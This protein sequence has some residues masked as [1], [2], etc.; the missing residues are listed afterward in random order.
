MPHRM[1][2]A[3]TF[4]AL[5]SVL[6]IASTTAAAT[7]QPRRTFTATLSGGGV[8]GTAVVTL[9]PNS[10]GTVTVQ[11]SGLTPNKVYA[12]QIYKGTCAKP[13]TLTKL[14]GL[15]TDSK[16]HGARTISLKPASGAPIWSV[17][18]TGTVAFRISAGKYVKCAVLKYPVATRVEISKYGIDLPIVYE[19]PGKYPYCNVAMYV[20]ELSQPTEAGPTMI[21]AHARVGMFLPL[22]TASKSNNG[23][24]MLGML[25][26]VWTS[27]SRL[28]V[29]KVTRVLRNVYGLPFG[30]DYTSERLWLQTSE[31]PHGTRHKLFV[32]ATRISTAPATWTDAHPKPKIV[33]CHP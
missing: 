31:G 25:V 16:G 10:A 27:D 32:Q 5:L 26:K 29:Y 7:V 6:L 3:G 2:R 12:Q 18:P 17:G 23:K 11:V 1:I 9:L 13:V 24:S 33:I 20:A 15:K 8:S 4:A 22:L 28:S 14:P 21:Y 30:N 19:A